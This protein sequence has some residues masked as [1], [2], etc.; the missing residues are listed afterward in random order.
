[1]NFFAIYQVVPTK[2]T[3]LTTV[4][5]VDNEEQYDGNIGAV[6]MQ[7]KISIACCL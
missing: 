1:V 3:F 7:R 6:H 4:N 2:T 5:T